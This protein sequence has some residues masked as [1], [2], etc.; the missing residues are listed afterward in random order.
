MSN[1]SKALGRSD[2]VEHSG[3]AADKNVRAPVASQK[4]SRFAQIFAYSN[5]AR[6]GAIRVVRRRAEDRRAL[7]A[8]TDRSPEALLPQLVC[9]AKSLPRSVTASWSDP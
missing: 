3:V 4:S 7:P 5:S 6:R 2:P 1:G 9:G 8:V